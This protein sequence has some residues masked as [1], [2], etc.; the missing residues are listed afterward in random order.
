[1]NGVEPKTCTLFPRLGHI[2]IDSNIIKPIH[3]AILSNWIYR[4]DTKS[5]KTGD[6]FIFTLGDGE[7]F[8]KIKLSRVSI[9]VAA[10]YEHQS[11][12]LNFGGGDLNV[13][14][15]IVSCQK[16]M[17]SYEHRILDIDNYLADEFEVF[18]ITTNF[19]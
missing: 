8:H 9:P 7:N 17:Q 14:D 1:M 3:A 12:G 13:N 19:I 6:S 15:R 18:S 5:F 4:K 11:G 2:P 10:I 16:S